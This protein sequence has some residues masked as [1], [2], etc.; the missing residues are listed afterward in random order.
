VAPAFPME[1]GRVKEKVVAKGKGKKVTAKGNRKVTAKGKGNVAAK[2]EGKVTAKGK[3][4]VAAKGKG[5]ARDEDGSDNE[6]DNEDGDN[7]LDP[8]YQDNH[9]LSALHIVQQ[10]STFMLPENHNTDSGFH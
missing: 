2:G 8:S 4:K 3:E 6:G 10:A 1:M 9:D 7:K 5:K